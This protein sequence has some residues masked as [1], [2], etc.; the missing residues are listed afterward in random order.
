M[1]SHVD[2][3]VTPSGPV[4]VKL[5][6]VSLKLRNVSLKLRNVSLKMY[7]KVQSAQS[8]WGMGGKSVVLVER[9]RGIWRE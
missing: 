7:G 6:N 1:D 2:Y 5:R 3:G 4:Y 9:E 8:E